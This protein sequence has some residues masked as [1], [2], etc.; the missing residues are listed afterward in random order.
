MKK[1]PQYKPNQVEEEILSLWKNEDT[2]KAS[3]EK[4][5]NG[6]PFSLQMDCRILV[7]A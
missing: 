4:T 2:F 7:T 1:I 3:L 5:K 6:E